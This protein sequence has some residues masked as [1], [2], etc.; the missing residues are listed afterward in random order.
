MGLVG[1]EA[2]LENGSQEIVQGNKQIVLPL[3]RE[4]YLENWIFFWILHPRQ[5]CNMQPHD[6]SE[7]LGSALC[8]S[9]MF[10]KLC[11]FP[12]SGELADTNMTKVGSF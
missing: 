11:L 5:H 6:P 8:P 12:S 2:Y 1:Y 9:Q 7:L 3:P 10:Q 4:M